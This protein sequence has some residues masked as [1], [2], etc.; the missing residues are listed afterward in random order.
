MLMFFYYRIT[1]SK[2]CGPFRIYTEMSVT[3][4]VTIDNLPYVNVLVLQNNAIKGMWTIQNL[5]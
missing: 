3:V 1:P 4:D 2:G 5:H